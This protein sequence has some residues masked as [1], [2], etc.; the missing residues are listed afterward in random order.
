[1]ETRFQIT[2]AELSLEDA[3]SFLCRPGWGAQSFFT[4][5]VRTP[6]KGKDVEYLE[7]E[8]YGP[9]CVRVLEGLA[10][11]ASE[12]W[13]T[14]P[15]GAVLSETALGG[16]YVAHRTGRLYPAEMSLI[17]GVGSP[18]R[19]AALKACDYLIERIKLA[20]PVWKL[21]HTSDGEEWV[22]GSL[23]VQAL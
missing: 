6:N 16:V 13:R 12:K 21:E 7:Y 15:E 8:A 9:M 1:M 11:E 4:G 3:L 17:V 14:G 18:H 10:L 2:E 20:L 23:S 22:E 19:R 5:T